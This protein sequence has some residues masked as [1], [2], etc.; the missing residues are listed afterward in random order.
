MLVLSDL[1]QQMGNNWGGADH[2]GGVQGSQAFYCYSTFD[3]ETHCVMETD[4]PSHVLQH[5]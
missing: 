2:R 1:G 4:T 5:N 3:T